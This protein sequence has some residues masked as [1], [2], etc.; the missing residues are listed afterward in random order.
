MYVRHILVPLNSV[1]QYYGVY[2]TLKYATCEGGQLH[3]AGW[4][5]RAWFCLILLPALVL[6]G[7]VVLVV[8]CWARWGA[9]FSAEMGGCCWLFAGC[10]WLAGHDA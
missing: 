5:G 10:H 4:C 7:G 3:N 1:E 6:P 2:L 9:A 8:G